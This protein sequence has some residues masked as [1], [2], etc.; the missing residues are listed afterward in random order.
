MEAQRYKWI[1]PLNICPR[2]SYWKNVKGMLYMKNLTLSSMFTAQEYRC[3]CNQTA[4]GVE[5][6]DE[7]GGKAIFIVSW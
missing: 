2:Y 3:M 7:F 4:F 1:S 6:L 5:V